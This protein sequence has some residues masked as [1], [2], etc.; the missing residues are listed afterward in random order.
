M[1]ERL[2]STTQPFQVIFEV[3]KMGSNQAKSSK[4]RWFYLASIRGYSKGKLPCSKLQKGTL[5]VLVVHN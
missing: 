3:K 1:F 5:L 2:I 4:G